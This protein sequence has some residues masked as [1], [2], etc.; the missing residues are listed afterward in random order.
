MNVVLVYLY[1]I[2]CNIVVK[3]VI[4]L[5]SFLDVCFYSISFF[6]YEKSFNV[7]TFV[8]NIQDFGLQT[9]LNRF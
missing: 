9:N 4:I 8:K 1:F 2:I 6:Y 3:F 7:C 5:E